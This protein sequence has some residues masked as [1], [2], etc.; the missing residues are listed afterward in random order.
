[1]LDNITQKI[2]VVLTPTPREALYNY[3]NQ[4]TMGEWLHKNRNEMFNRITNK[5]RPEACKDK[6]QKTRENIT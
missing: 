5:N 4:N 6:L 2:L 1:M 3:K